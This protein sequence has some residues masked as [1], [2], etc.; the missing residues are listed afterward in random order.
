MQLVEV[1]Q[2][3]LIQWFNNRQKKQELSVLLQ[4]IQLPQHL[5]EAQEPLPDAKS[6]R[7][8]PDQPGEQH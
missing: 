4:G 3:T 7:T 2:N 5:P 8:E 6:L 1:N